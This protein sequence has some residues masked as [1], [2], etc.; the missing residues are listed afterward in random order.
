[1]SFLSSVV[2]SDSGKK[3]LNSRVIESLMK[4]DKTW[5]I[6][7]DQVRGSCKGMNVNVKC[8]RQPA[9]SN[10]RIKRQS[11]ADP[12]YQDVYNV[13]I[14]FPTNNDPVINVNTQEKSLVETIVQKAVLEGAIFDVRDTLPNVIPD[15]TSLSLVTDY[16]CPPG[17]VVRDKSCVECSLGTYFN[18]QTE[19]CVECP[20][21]TY[22][23][24]LGQSLCKSC[25]NISGKHGV[26][27]LV[28]ARSS[29]E[30]KEKCSAGKY[31]DDSIGLCRPCGYGLYQP[32]EGAFHCIQCGPGMT[33][34]S[35]EAVSQ[36]ECRRKLIII[37]LI[38]I[39]NS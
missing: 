26:T 15:L 24:E 3:I 6:C 39:H 34:R 13:E 11:N 23:N 16:A 8:V 22:Q 5:K 10:S 37:K 20:I 31:Y 30:C 2:C 29:N 9:G 14:A 36:Q 17:Q 33:T 1:M 28:G 12:D 25:P 27:A 21:G 38:L 32:H 18:E 4:V 7:S 19:S 35:Q